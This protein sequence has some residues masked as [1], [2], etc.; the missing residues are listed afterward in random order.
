MIH[1]H[2]CFWLGNVEHLIIYPE[3][4]ISQQKT[5]QAVFHLTDKFWAL[6]VGECRGAGEEEEEEDRFLG[7]DL[8]FIV[9]YESRSLLDLNSEILK[10]MLPSP[11]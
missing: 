8:H 2:E 7:L 1:L 6:Y 11:M 9:F 5:I 10:C 4:H 3:C